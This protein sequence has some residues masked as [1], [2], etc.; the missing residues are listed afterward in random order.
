[1]GDAGQLGRVQFRLT[2]GRAR[3]GRQQVLGMIE[4]VAQTS[5]SRRMSRMCRRLE[6]AT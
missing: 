1:M 4:S 6:G 3:Y 2:E 5:A